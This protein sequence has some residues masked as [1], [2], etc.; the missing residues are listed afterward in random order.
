M[1]F[2]DWRI[3]AKL[4]LA[5]V[6]VVVLAA[7]LGAVS[8]VQLARI[9]AA[10]DDMATRL[11][12]SVAQAG[13]VRVLLNRMRRSEAGLVTAQ[14]Q[15]DMQKAVDQVQARGADLQ[16]AEAQYASLLSEGAR[17]FSN[18]TRTARRSTSS[19]MPTWPTLPKA[20]TTAVPRRWNCRAITDCP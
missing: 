19:C 18:S 4:G 13:E 10:A 1:R 8:L 11:L 9:H 20:W 15:D 14:R 16:K 2:S 5:F 12:P 17:S 3:G 6:L 7:V